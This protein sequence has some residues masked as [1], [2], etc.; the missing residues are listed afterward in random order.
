MQEVVKKGTVKTDKGLEFFEMTPD[1]IDAAILEMM[2]DWEDTIIREIA[3]A[4]DVASLFN[5]ATII[6]TLESFKWAAD[7]TVI[8]WDELA[9]LLN[10]F[11]DAVIGR[12]KAE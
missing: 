5:S 9:G 7:M 8:T 3:D 10:G 2:D 12:I 6:S 1:Q 11:K 4:E